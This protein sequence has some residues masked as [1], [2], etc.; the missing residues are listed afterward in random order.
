MFDPT[1]FDN[2]KVVLEGAVYERDLRGQIQITDRKDLIDMAVM[3][4]TYSIYFQKSGA[5]ENAPRA[6]LT[7]HAPIADLAAELLERDGAAPGCE[8]LVTFELDVSEPEIACPI[9]E[10][11]LK[12]LWENRPEI[13]QRVSYPYGGN[14]GYEIQV[15]LG[16]NRKIDE[17]NVQDVTAVFLHTCLSLDWFSDWASQLPR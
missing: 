10:N 11:R 13:S 6:G 9:I 7:L 5:E 14:E 15:T 17:S 16:F 2:L 12:H 3:S 4:R 8:L 1:I